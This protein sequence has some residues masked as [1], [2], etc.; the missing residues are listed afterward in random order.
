MLLHVL[1]CLVASRPDVGYCQVIEPFQSLALRNPHPLIIMFALFL[2][3]VQGMNYVVAA[4]LLG[5]ISETYTNITEIDAVVD[6]DGG[7]GGDNG[8]EG[9]GDNNSTSEPAAAIVKAPIEY[10]MPGTAQLLLGLL[11]RVRLL[12]SLTQ[13]TVFSVLP[14]ELMDEAEADVYLAMMEMLRPDSK[15]DMAGMWKERIPKLKLRIYQLD[16]YLP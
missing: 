2:F 10:S 13:I 8:D 7:D 11:T 9:G 1:L 12:K 4:L 15:L 14:V 16:R 3:L 6:G 5:R